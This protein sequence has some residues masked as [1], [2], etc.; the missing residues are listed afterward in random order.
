MEEL[1]LGYDLWKCMSYAHHINKVQITVSASII[2]YERQLFVFIY[3]CVCV[4]HVHEDVCVSLYI[5]KMALF[6]HLQLS[7]ALQKMI[8]NVT[9]Y[10]SCVSMK[11]C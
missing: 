9:I 8:K 2:V 3:I 10:S 4:F 6:Q 5:L 1:N 7:G 11:I